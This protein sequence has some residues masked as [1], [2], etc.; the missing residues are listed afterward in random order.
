MGKSKWKGA[1]EGEKRGNQDPGTKPPVTAPLSLVEWA[2]ILSSGRQE[3]GGRRFFLFVF[4][5]KNLKRGRNNKT[6]ASR[7]ER[8][9]END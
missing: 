3:A 7:A 1:K 6:K 8:G 4:G 5:W 9:I 2:R